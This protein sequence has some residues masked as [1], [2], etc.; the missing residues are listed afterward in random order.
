MK[1]SRSS[2]PVL[3][4]LSQAALEGLDEEGLPHLDSLNVVT[5]CQGDD[6]PEG[7]GMTELTMLGL[8]AHGRSGSL[9]ALGAAIRAGPDL[10]CNFLAI[11]GPRAAA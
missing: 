3:A 11:T 5:S 10:L 7:H 2:S 9:V 4:G 8:N 6:V 1:I